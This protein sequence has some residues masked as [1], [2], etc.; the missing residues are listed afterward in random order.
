M[1]DVCANSDDEL[2]ILPFTSIDV[3]DAPLNK[4]ADGSGPLIIGLEARTEFPKIQPLMSRQ[5]LTILGHLVSRSMILDGF[6]GEFWCLD[7]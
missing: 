2:N 7:Q 1:E 6:L 4:H 3:N 5:I